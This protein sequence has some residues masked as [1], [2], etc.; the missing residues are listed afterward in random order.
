MEIVKN[1]DEKYIETDNRPDKPAA[2]GGRFSSKFS[3]EGFSG[4]L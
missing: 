2:T 3:R 4:F 1:N